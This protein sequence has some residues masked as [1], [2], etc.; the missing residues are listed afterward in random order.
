MSI[1]DDSTGLSTTYT[2]Q[3]VVAFTAGTLA[4]VAA[5]ITEVEAKLKRGTLSASTNPTGS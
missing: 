4:N 2:E 1:T 5:C 3:T